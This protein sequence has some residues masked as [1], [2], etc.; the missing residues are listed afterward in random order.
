M[1]I[2]DLFREFDSI[3]QYRCIENNEDKI[4][5]SFPDNINISS[6]MFIDIVLSPSPAKT[7][8]LEQFD[9]RNNKT[10]FY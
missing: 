7:D 8:W 4:P 3:N 2:P 1:I 9:C 10:V 5:L 6:D